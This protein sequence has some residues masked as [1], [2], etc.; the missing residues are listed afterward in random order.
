MDHA[1]TAGHR[2]TPTHVVRR[3]VARA[4]S[5]CADPQREDVPR[6]TMDVFFITAVEGLRSLSGVKIE[7][8]DDK[9]IYE[10]AAELAERATRMKQ[11]DDPIRPR[12]RG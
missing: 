10:V 7:W 5:T 1:H 11:G 2:V 12:R 6:E 9:P 3:A 8:T 4:S